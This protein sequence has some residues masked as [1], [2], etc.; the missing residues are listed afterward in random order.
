MNEVILLGVPWDA[1]SSFMRGSALAPDN[2]RA[3][4]RCDS[5]NSY[6]ENGVDVLN[7]PMLRDAGNLKDLCSAADYLTIEKEIA[8][9]LETGAKVLALGGDH[10]ITYPL[11]RAYHRIYPEFDLFQLDA[12][13]DTYDQFD[14]NKYSHAC[15]F[16]RIMEEKIP[17]R[18]VQIGVRALT[19]HQREQAK[20]FGIQTIE[21]K[22]W[23]DGCR[24]L[25][26]TR[27]VYI[28]LD[29]DV[30]DPAFVPGVSHHEPGGASVRDVI[31]I[32][33]S[34]QAPVIGCDLVEYNPQR[35]IM[36]MTGMVAAK[37]VRELLSVLLA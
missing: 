36:G 24:Q 22:N 20:R 29:L 23:T 35:D 9:Y 28:S 10:S 25:E 27:P 30:I 17:Q 32:I 14:G 3:S 11:A 1:S 18:L 13:A 33:Q 2:I 15:P 7:H 4:L 31:Q 34:I 8:R 19:T 6:A 37:L 12:H 26:F 16:A 5:A 21:M